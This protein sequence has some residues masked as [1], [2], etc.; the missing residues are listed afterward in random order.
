MN[1]PLQVV[2]D[3]GHVVAAGLFAVLAI[4]IGRR[5][6]S[7][8][9]GKL[10][11]AAL[12]L[13]AIWSLSIAF[14]GVHQ[15]ESGIMES[16]R[17][18]GW[19]ACLFALPMQASARLP[20]EPGRPSPPR[21]RGA[22]AVYAVLIAVLGAQSVVDMMWAISEPGAGTA[23]VVET[24]LILRMMWAIGALVLIQR[25]FSTADPVA[26]ARVAPLIGAMAAM[27]T[28]DLVLYSSA[29][30]AA[31]VAS[32]LYVLRGGA[33]AA[34]VPVIALVIQTQANLQIRP[35][36][37]LARRGLGVVAV[38]ALLVLLMIGL[39]LVEEIGSPLGRLIATGAVFALIV[40][41]L[42][43]LPTLRFR[44]WVRVMV[45]KHFFRHRYD[46]REQWM[47]FADTIGQ[48]ISTDAS[49]Y[50][51]AIK[52][53]ADITGSPGGALLLIAEDGQRLAVHSQWNWTGNGVDGCV[54]DGSLLDALRDTFWIID[55]DGRRAA[56]DGPPLPD[57]LM[58]DKSAWALVPIIHFDQLTG[59]LLLARPRYDRAL[60]WE[61]FDMLRT[62]GRQVASYIAEAQG[63]QALAD[64]RRFDEFNRRFAFIMHDIK[65]LVSQLALLARNA[66]RH[67]DNP[68]FRSDMV[69]TLQDCVGKMNDLLARLSQ[70]NSSAAAEAMAFSLGD[71][72]QR[73][74]RGRGGAHAILTTGDLAITASADPARVEQIVRHLIQ[75]A[76]EAS[77]PDAPVVLHIER[78]GGMACLS[79]IDKGCGMTGEF[80]RDELFRPFASTKTGGFGIGAYEARALA[81]AM[82]GRLSVES[83]PGKGSRF[84]LWLPLADTAAPSIAE[85]RAA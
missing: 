82:G 80:I 21:A 9:E 34:L 75:N 72:A 70:H 41:G 85:E 26:R 47:G 68:D 11:V 74:A 64:A 14:E 31:G 18:C 1:G 40:G 22:V 17:N 19:L 56:Q 76:M 50:T 71:V 13:T 39:S 24:G 53:V 61:D 32:L 69:L 84:T 28:Y 8:M 16:L 46:Y 27:W 10:L 37:A 12:S 55:I 51:R 63:Q 25:I 36:R 2:G 4:G 49:L 60:D 33:M 29:Y 35:S 57:W 78:S 52:A 54:I 5:W 66:Q 3:W 45:A 62:A 48:A 20:D 44:S 67:A 83:V 6:S 30:S 15:L 38:L 65:N 42:L 73:V 77:G 23:A 79:V 59:A 81:L 43:V 7:S 58:G